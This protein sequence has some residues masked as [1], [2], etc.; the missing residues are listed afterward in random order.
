MNALDDFFLFIQTGF[1][2]S[3]NAIGSVIGVANLHTAKTAQVFVAL[4]LPLGDQCLV[5]NLVLQTKIVQFSCDGLSF[6]EQIVNVTTSLVMNLKDRPK[7]FYLTLSFVTF[8]LRLSHFSLQFFQRRFNQ[9][10]SFRR[11]RV[12][13]QPSNFRHLFFP[14]PWPV[15]NDLKN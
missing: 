10:P 4:F 14:M 3:A 6:V 1:G 8:A 9:I 5:S 11:F 13:A 2:H 15:S 12:R 7:R